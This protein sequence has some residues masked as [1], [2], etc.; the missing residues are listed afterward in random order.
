[1][2]DTVQHDTPGV[3]VWPPVLYGVAAITLV[4]LDWRVPWSLGG[5]PA[6][7][8][9]GV[10]LLVLGVAFNVWGSLV[11]RRG[12]TNINPALPTKALVLSGPFRLS[13]NPLYVAAAVMFIGLTLIVDSVWG[14]LIL[15]PVLAVMHFGVILREERY[16][17]RKFGEGFRRYRARVRRYL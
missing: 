9:A 10:V 15:V 17:E 2:G 8:W 11:M 6:A 14:L 12:G 3:I 13:R 7:L 1:M 4:A 16:L 5:H